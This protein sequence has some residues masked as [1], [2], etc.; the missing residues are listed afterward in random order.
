MQEP[1]SVKPEE[2]PMSGRPMEGFQMSGR[3]ATVEIALLVGLVGGAILGVLGFA[4]YGAERFIGSVPIAVDQAMGEQTA[5]LL[6]V[7]SS[8]C[9]DPAPKKYVETVVA[10]LLAAIT[11]SGDHRFAFQFVVVD[12][13]EV[14]AFALPGGFVTVNRGLLE[15]AESGDEVAAVLAHEIQHVLRRHGTVRMLRELGASTLLSAIFGGT[16]IAVP[17]KATHDFVSNAYDRAQESEADERGL[18]LMVKAGLD[19]RGMSRFFARLAK[20][21]MTPPALLSTHPDP[22][23]RAEKAARAAEGAKVTTTLPSPKGMK[24]R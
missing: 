24:C 15:S 23:D 13:P 5:R 21:G 3:R 7:T 12:D 2:P 20:T 10:P 1:E 4:R 6:S 9:T 16:D 18:A 14:N 8:P 11:S 22:G 17:A 19:P